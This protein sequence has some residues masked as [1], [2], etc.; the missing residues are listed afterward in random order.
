MI[1]VPN[2]NSFSLNDVVA[3]TGGTSEQAAFNN[4]IDAFFDLSYKGSKDR[5]TNFRNYTSYQVGDVYLGG[6]IAYIYQ[7]GDPGFISGEFHGIIAE[8]A[9]DTTSRTWYNG[10]FTTTGATSQALGSGE[11]N[12]GLIVLSQGAGSYSARAAYDFSDGS[13][14]DWSLPS[15]DELGKMWFNRSL[16]GGFNN[17]ANYWTSSE[18]SSNNAM[19]CYW[20]DGSM[21]A[22]SKSAT[23]IG[24][25]IRYF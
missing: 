18:T 23:A 7:S 25:W 12:T 17:T 8:N 16:I 19:R 10:S 11:D 13:Y 22:T 21:A 14:S 20:G 3:I 4:S 1:S 5:L 9:D 24:R 6:I 2:N 15:V